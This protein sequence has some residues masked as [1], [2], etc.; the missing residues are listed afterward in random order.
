MKSTKKGHPLD[1]ET[2]NQFNEILDR[3]TDVTDELDAINRDPLP[4]VKRFETCRQAVH[5]LV[6][7]YRVVLAQLPA[8]EQERVEQRVGQKVIRLR[9]KADQT[10][11]AGVASGDKVP[12]AANTQWGPSGITSVASESPPQ[13]AS[14][15]PPRANPRSTA[16]AA[17]RE[18]ES[19]CGPCKDL[20]LH[21]I[22][23]MVGDE[24]KQVVCESCGARHG[25][26][27]S[28]VQKRAIPLTKRR[29]RAQ[30]RKNAEKERMEAEL[31]ALRKELDEATEVRPFEERRRYRVGEII[32]HPE[33]GRG[34]VE[35]ATRG[36]ILVRFRDRRLPIN[37]A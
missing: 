10:L 12:L 28:P 8:N 25:Y 23:A 35:Y 37:N 30:E 32:E 19:W 31:A 3:I 1:D 20:R 21:T 14:S 29:D 33:H 26:R 11:P 9:R 7:D 5:R 17:G 36:S 13:R 15:S 27:K 16:P 2:H 22:I 6:A 24:P 4:G 18:I 34:K